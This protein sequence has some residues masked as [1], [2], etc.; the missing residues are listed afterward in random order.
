MAKRKEKEKTKRPKKYQ[1]KLNLNHLTFEQVVDLSL[2][3]KP[4]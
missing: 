4:V 3:K 1:T 2:R